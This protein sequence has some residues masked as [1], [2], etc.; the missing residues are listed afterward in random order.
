METRALE[1]TTREVESRRVTDMRR[2]EGQ[3]PSGSAAEIE[4]SRRAGYGR[5]LKNQLD[6]PCG[7]VEIAMRVEIEVRRAERLTIPRERHGN[8]GRRRIHSS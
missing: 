4:Q 7:I 1:Q 2:K 5:D 6:G 8:I 3:M